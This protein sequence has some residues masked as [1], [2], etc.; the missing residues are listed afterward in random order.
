MFDDN[1]GARQT[2]CIQ[3]ASQCTRISLCQTEYQALGEL[4][5]HGTREPEY[6]VVGVTGRITDSWG[7]LQ[8]GCPAGYLEIRCYRPSSRVPGIQGARQG[9][10]RS[11][12]HAGYQTTKVPER[13]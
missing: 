7:T 12:C 9:I 1:R 13:A 5:N 11:V 3:D 6:N 4:R 8:T 10:K 2:G